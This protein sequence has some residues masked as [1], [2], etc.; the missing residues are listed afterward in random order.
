MI[1]PSLCTSKANSF[2]LQNVQFSAV[3]LVASEWQKEHSMTKLLKRIPRTE[4]NKFHDTDQDE[5]TENWKRKEGKYLSVIKH[6]RS[7]FISSMAAAMD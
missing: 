4:E 5:W 6:Y 7:I 1:Y 2:K 3:R